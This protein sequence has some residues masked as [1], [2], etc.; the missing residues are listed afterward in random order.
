MQSI[1]GDGRT[2]LFVSHNM[3]TVNKLCNRCI[4]L[5]SGKIEHSGA[6]AEVVTRY[7]QAPS[8]SGSKKT[9]FAGPKGV[10]RLLECANIVNG[11]E[12][13]SPCIEEP[14][15]MQV[16]FEVFER[17]R[18]NSSIHVFD[19]NGAWAF[20][21]GS[22]S[23]QHEVGIYHHRYLMPANLLNDGHYSIKVLFVENGNQ[24]ISEQNNAHYFY[25]VEKDGRENV[26]TIGGA[27]RPLIN[28]EEC[29]MGVSDGSSI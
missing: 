26:W 3:T 12:T 5:A 17:R 27:V 7:L 8:V 19:K 22:E 21:A 14:F 20:C 4:L 2:V 9:H 16:T 23:K 25:A 29:F 11:K 28:G 24:I 18:L 13:L 6:T 10:V 1:S 15:S